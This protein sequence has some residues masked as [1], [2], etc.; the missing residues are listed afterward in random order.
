MQI[1]P[2]GHKSAVT[3]A[4]LKETQSKIKES[5]TP[6]AC[7]VCIV[8]SLQQLGHRKM[9]DLGA[10]SAYAKEIG[11]KDIASELEASYNEEKKVG[12]ELIK[13]AQAE[14]NK[15]AHLEMTA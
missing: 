5:A 8:G 4:I 12:K 3:E 11:Q 15:S 14:I 10:L 9:A 2:K 13:L 6:E 1:T 7:D